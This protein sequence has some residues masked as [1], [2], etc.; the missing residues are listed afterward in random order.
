[1]MRGSFVGAVSAFTTG[2]KMAPKM[3]ELYG[4]RAKA[5]LALENIRKAVEDATQVSSVN[6]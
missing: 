3:G 4:G 2:I 6:N 1:M 5:H